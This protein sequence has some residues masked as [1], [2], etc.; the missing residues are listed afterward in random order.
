MLG[1]KPQLSELVYGPGQQTVNLNSAPITIK[2]PDG[3]DLNGD[4]YDYHIMDATVNAV[5]TSTIK[6][7][8]FPNGDEG[9]NHRDYGLKGRS[10]TASASVADSSGNSILVGGMAKATSARPSF[11][12]CTITGV[13]SVERSTPSKIIYQDGTATAVGE[14]DNY[15]QNTVD[16]LT[17]LLLKADVSTDITFN[18]RV[19]RTLK[20]ASGNLW[21]IMPG[22]L[23]WTAESSS[24]SFTGIDGDADEEY[25]IVWD[26]DQTFRYTFNLDAGANYITQ[27]AQNNNATIVSNNTTDSQVHT[28]G[29]QSEVIISTVSGKSRLSVTTGSIN[30]APTQQDRR[31]VSWQNTIDKIT[32][33]EVVPNSSTTATATLYRKRKKDTPG[34]DFPWQ[35]VGRLP[36][37]GDYSSGSSYSFPDDITGDKVFSYRALYKGDDTTTVTGINMRINADATSNKTNQNLDSN[38]A[39]TSAAV[40]TTTSFTDVFMCEQVNSGELILYP[41]SNFQRPAISQSNSDEDR[42]RF[43]GHFDANTVDE[44]LSLFFFASNSSSLDGEII[45]QVLK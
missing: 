37:S 27:R 31:A 21:D 15:W 42:I 24:K 43:Q 36:V 19:Y 39:T 11:S 40:A 29:F 7:R 18:I 16:K 20:V 4:I 28:G 35:T 8:I 6:V 10:A 38:N 23:I 9:T 26:G 33:I 44:V 30:S 5:S 1:F 2:N 34:D 13:S 12:I 22:K 25:Q 41:K 14:N 3:S 45:I 32:S 17:S